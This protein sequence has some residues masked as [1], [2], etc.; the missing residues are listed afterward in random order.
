MEKWTPEPPY[1]KLSRFISMDNF[2]K[3]MQLQVDRMTPDHIVYL[4]VPEMLHLKDVAIER[5]DKDME[6]GVT[7]VLKYVSTKVELDN[8]KVFDETINPKF[9]VPS[10]SY[11]INGK[12][13]AGIPNN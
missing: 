4:F 11:I 2:V 8:F 1:P 9:I 10:V 12:T 6:N 5:G 7:E 13:P 3:Q